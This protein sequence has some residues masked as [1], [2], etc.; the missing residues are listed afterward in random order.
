MGWCES[1]VFTACEGS[2]DWSLLSTFMKSKLPRFI[3]QIDR[4]GWIDRQTGKFISA[5][6]VNNA[7]TTIKKFKVKEPKSFFC[8][9]CKELLLKEYPWSPYNIPD[10][11]PICGRCLNKGIK[12]L[13]LQLEATAKRSKKR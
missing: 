11:I 4:L 3:K 8:P 2:I 10:A 5:L 13:R 7:M 12:P 1:I 9:N 6:E